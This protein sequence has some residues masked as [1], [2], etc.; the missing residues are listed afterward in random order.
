MSAIP[1][2]QNVSPVRIVSHFLLAQKFRK[3]TASQK[4]P[5]LI[6]AALP[7]IELSAAAVAFGKR[8][9]V[10]V[11]IDVRDLWPDALIGVLP[12]PARRVGRMCARPLFEMT[13]QSLSGAT[14]IIA[15]SDGYLDWALRYAGRQRKPVDRVFMHG[16]ELVQCTCDEMHEEMAALRAMGLREH[17]FVCWFVGTF[18]TTYDLASV[19]KA[20]R[21]LKGNNTHDIQFVLSGDGPKRREWVAAASDLDN[22]IFTGW[23]DGTR[24][25]ALMHLASVGLACYQRTAP[26]GLPFKL[27][28]YMAGGL[29]V[30]SSLRGEAERFLDSKQCG[31]TYE[32]G[33]PTALSDALL[34]LICNR[35]LHERM[36]MNARCAYHDELSSDV[37]YHRMVSH[38]EE[39]CRVSSKS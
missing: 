20:A 4:P 6:I 9:A 18:G 8:H 10:P 28:E 33:S 35:P 27:F 36:S 30:I 16:Y 22:V 32:A 23:V 21:R 24:L 7:T 13:R 29:P 11:I 31:I 38:F 19:I 37:I 26:Q 39:V 5:E 17:S 2:R 3:I 1:Y 25:A 15:V 12:E 34:Q 14:G